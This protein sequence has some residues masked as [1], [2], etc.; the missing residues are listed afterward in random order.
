MKALKI[1]GIWIGLVL[2]YAPSFAQVVDVIPVNLVGSSDPIPGPDAFIMHPFTPSP[3]SG[4]YHGGTSYGEDEKW[5]YNIS[6]LTPGSVYNLTIYYMMDVVQLTPIDTRV[7]N[8]TMSSGATLSATLIPFVIPANW[9]IWYSLTTTFT[10]VAATD[11]IDIE[12]FSGSDNSTWLFTDIAIDGGGGCEDLTIVASDTEICF[13]DP[14]TLTA[15]ST[16]GGTVTWDGGVTNGVAFT[17]VL[18]GT[19]TYTTTSTSPDD[20]PYSQTITVIDSPTIDAGP[21]L[22][23]CLGEDVTLTG[24]GAGVGGDYVWDLGVVDGVAFDPLASNTYTVVGT[25]AA[26]CSS[27]DEVTIVVNPSMTVSFSGDELIGCTPFTVNFTSLVP[28]AIYNWNFGDGGSSSASAP[29]HTYSTAGEF[30]VSLNMINADGCTGSVTYINYITVVP[31]PIAAFTYSPTQV[32]VT[33]TEVKF[34]NQSLY[35]TSY[36]WDFGDGSAIS[37]AENPIHLFPEVGDMRYPVTLTVQNELG[38]S[39]MIQKI[40]EV[41]DVLIFHI[42]NSFTPD[43]DT[44]NETF[45]PVFYSGVDI[46]D[47]HFVIFNRWGEIVFESY[48]PASGWNGAYGNQGLVQDGV[49]IWRL[50]FGETMSDKKRTYEGHVSVNR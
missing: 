33:D 20:C 1:V 35:A 25:T 24:S 10:A 6:G 8:L 18:P 2:I 16:T 34:T 7:G 29:S 11:R 22:E 36:S 27:E 31:Q 28:G 13:G 14:V 15:T 40:I 43:G 38:C 37:N 26:G 32:D 50:E 44:F 41:Q 5:G 30:S 17:P 12:S 47:F 42:P 45:N 21:D 4:T 48:N 46:F 39:D 49:Y 23:I 3:L 9:R 19:Y